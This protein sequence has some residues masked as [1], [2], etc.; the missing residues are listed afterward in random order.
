MLH[1][2]LKD[3]KILK[4]SETIKSSKEVINLLESENFF[5]INNKILC[6]LFSTLLLKTFLKTD[7]Q[8][9][10]VIEKQSINKVFKNSIINLVK[11]KAS[12]IIFTNKKLFYTIEIKT[13]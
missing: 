8:T 10:I 6:E 3:N 4:L 7:S 5:I 9:L 13:K 12:V 2:S 1:K 11:I